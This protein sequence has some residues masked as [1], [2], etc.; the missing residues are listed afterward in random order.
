MLP[1]LR[2]EEFDDILKELHRQPLQH[3]PYRLK[4]G[5]GKSQ[6][7]GLINRRGEKPD[8]SRNNW[9][10]PYLY[11]LLIEF[12][13]KHVTVPWS[14]VTVNENY[15]TKPHKDKHNRGPSFLVGFGNYTGGNL[16][17]HEG[18]LSGS[19]CIRGQPLVADFSKV[20]HS[21]EAF[22]GERF[23]LVFYDF[24]TPRL[25]ALPPFSVKN[26][27]GKWFFYRGDQKITKAV[28]LPHPLRGRKKTAIVK[29]VKEVTINFP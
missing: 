16:L 23:S 4:A 12:A 11:H 7:W 10:R 25:E 29:E 26:E 14:A 22:S 24:W 5:A 2:A 18:D 27:D 9:M 28:G 8:A 20:L 19:H 15:Q 3:N 13:S 17:I 6:T 1:P 21:T